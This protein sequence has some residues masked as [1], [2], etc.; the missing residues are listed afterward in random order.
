MESPGCEVPAIDILVGGFSRQTD[1]ILFYGSFA[2]LGHSGCRDI[3]VISISSLS[4]SVQR[5]RSKSVCYP[6][7]PLNLYVVPE[8]SVRQDLQSFRY[9]GWWVTK[10]L[11]GFASGRDE[12]ACARFFAAAIGAYSS[13]TAILLEGDLDGIL[14]RISCS[15]CVRYPTFIKSV[16]RVFQNRIRLEMFR[17]QIAAAI[18]NPLTNSQLQIGTSD[19]LLASDRRRHY[20]EMVKLRP[21]QMGTDI[22][23]AKVKLRE[24]E[25]FFRT[26][27]IFLRTLFGKEEVEQIGSAIIEVE[28]LLDTLEYMSSKGVECL[29][30]PA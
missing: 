16:T 17:A 29:D 30:E 3:D 1:P 26:A 12:S 24:A 25:E 15:L 13:R 28:N 18:A 19:H 20:W 14:R 10:P 8:S 4:T 23:P 21:L 22:V 6:G 5:I 11:L 7:Q 2:A 27:Q 9:G